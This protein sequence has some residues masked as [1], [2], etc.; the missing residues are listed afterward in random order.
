MERG[1]RREVVAELLR[2]APAAGPGLAQSPSKGDRPTISVTLN[3]AIRYG[4]G[5]AALFII[6][7]SM[8]T[9]VLARMPCSMNAGMET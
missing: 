8:T 9:S 6:V 1:A 4:F 5:G 2:P 7:S 3:A